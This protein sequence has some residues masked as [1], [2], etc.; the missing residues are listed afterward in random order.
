MRDPVKHSLESGG[1]LGSEQAGQR[2]AAGA[3]PGR[4]GGLLRGESC[5]HWGRDCRLNWGHKARVLQLEQGHTC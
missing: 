1:P 2:A 4:E 3:G 5:G